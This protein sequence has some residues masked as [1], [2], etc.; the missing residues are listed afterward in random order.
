MPSNPPHTAMHVWD[1]FVRVFHWVLV[2]CVLL[3]FFILDDGE[4][5]HQWL[6]YT[7]SALIGARI[8]W[9]FVGTEHARFA[10]FFPT[11]KRLLEHLKGLASGKP[12]FHPGHNPLGALMMLTLMVLAL[13]LGLSGY[14]QTTDRFWG[15]EWLQE[16]HEVLA[17]A[18][19]GLAAVHATAAIVMGRFE[20]VN[21]VGAMI[22]GVKH[23]HNKSNHLQ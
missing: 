22:T 6:G 16:V 8:V 13:A 4:T 18:L 7:A 17:T 14:L 5:L 11:P 10:N 1:P 15:E 3:N 21:L 2:S 23:L 20:G 19:I 12:P 9:G